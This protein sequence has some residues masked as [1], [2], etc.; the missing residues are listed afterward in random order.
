MD[1]GPYKFVVLHGTSDLTGLLGAILPGYDGENP[2]RYAHITSST[3]TI[4]RNQVMTGAW[5]SLMPRYS[6]VRAVDHSSRMYKIRLETL[7][8]NE[9]SPD[10][11]LY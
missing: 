4:A 5:D 9:S 2:D 1:S 8:T 3:R 10:A 11:I 6:Q 7:T